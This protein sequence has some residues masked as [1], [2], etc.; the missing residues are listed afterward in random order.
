MPSS[1]VFR[2]F[3]RGQLR[4]GSKHGPK[5]TSRKQA[6]AIY[7]SE[8][9]AEAANGGTYPEH[10]RKRKRRTKAKQSPIHRAMSARTV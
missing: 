7:E 8:R 5:V 3:Q 9:R 2:K 6:I 1:E 10:G 4:S